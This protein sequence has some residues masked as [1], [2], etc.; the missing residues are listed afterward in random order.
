MPLGAP[1]GGGVATRAAAASMPQAKAPTQSPVRSQQ[2]SAPTPTPG[3]GSRAS[4]LPAATGVGSGSPGAGGGPRGAGNVAPKPAIDP[5]V[6]WAQGQSAINNASAANYQ[7]GLDLQAGQAQSHYNTGVGGLQAQ[8]GFD[9]QYL[10]NDQFRLGADRNLWAAK[11]VNV[12]ANWDVAQR[13]YADQAAQNADRWKL[14][15]Q[16]F[17]NNN[18]G[19]KS[20]YQSAMD[21]AGLSY[22]RT[23][24]QVLS[25]NTARGA[26]F[27]Q[28]F[29]DTNRETQR[30]FDNTS[31]DASRTRDVALT[32]N[33]ISYDT[34]SSDLRASD[35]ANQ[36]T[37]DSDVAS[38]NLA[39]AQQVREGDYLKALGSDYGLK[40]D[41]IKDALSR[42]ISKLGLDYGSTVAQLANLKAQGTTD[43]L[44]QASA[45]A[46]QLLNANLGSSGQ[47]ALATTA[48]GV[49]PSMRTPTKPPSAG[50]VLQSGLGQIGQYYPSV[51]QY[52]AATGVVGNK[53]GTPTST[54][55]RRVS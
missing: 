24:R 6:Q 46:Y 36:R 13:R 11:N 10:N 45:L 51:A 48:P 49:Q 39:G 25:D 3:I 53:L 17:D 55:P 28:G 8:A 37:M 43:S 27:A 52:G 19:I 35:L 47:A 22:D 12:G 5:Y 40:A 30:Q 2:T 42:G 4:T 15:G 9:Q 44:A 20:R 54:A 7:S 38:T 18:T 31:S 23:N 26:T 21:A 1:S 32:G 34:N 50:D 29:G 14:S 33:Q 16:T 41:Q